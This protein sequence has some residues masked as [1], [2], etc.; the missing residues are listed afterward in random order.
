[1]GSFRASTSPTILTDLD[2]DSGT[3]S[4][5]TANDRVGIGTTSPTAKLEVE[6]SS[7]GG[8][9]VVLI[10]NDDADQITLDIDAVSTGAAVVHVT[11]A[12]VN[13]QS[14]V[15]IETTAA[16]TDAVLELRNSNSALDKPP[17]LKF[18]RSDSTAEA[19]NMDLGQI[20][21]FGVD[22]GNTSTEYVQVLAEGPD[23]TNTTEDGR[24]TFD[25]RKTGTLRNHLSMGNGNIVFNEDSKD[26]N[27]RIE[28][29]VQ[30]EAFYIDG[31][32]GAISLNYTSAAAPGGGFDQANAV[33]AKVSKIN[34]EIVTTILVDIDGL[35]VGA[36]EKD[37][38]GEDGV[39]AAYLTQITTAVNGV[40]YKAEM[41]CVETPATLSGATTADIDLV[42][43]S[44]SLAQGAD[45]DSAGTAV[46]LI[47]AT[48]GYK[49]GT[50]RQ[51]AAGAD[52]E[53]VVDD[54]LYLAAGAAPGGSGGRYGAGKF[55]IKLYGASFVGQD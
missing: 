1:M 26:I 34:G 45:Y 23:V 9:T 8:E 24:I 55:I 4:V 32:D 47:A 30:T 13:D 39:A 42:S 10:D 22:D 2:V 44:N 49:A 38:I 53:N 40:I 16:E 14:I 5:D 33:S 17:I 25:I 12:A 21:F 19:D 20:S 41:S 3:I 6:Q 31:E 11:N 35:S 43:N 18:N 28:S 37:V 54:Y 36:G 52:F 15:L 50:H 27:F 7:T 51:S 46:V 29:D 48:A